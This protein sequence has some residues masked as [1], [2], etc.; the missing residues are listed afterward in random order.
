M[1]EPVPSGPILRRYFGPEIT[2]LR[3][4]SRREELELERRQLTRLRSRLD[5]R[6]RALGYR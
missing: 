1:N 6:L 4:M 3:V 5:A 2:K